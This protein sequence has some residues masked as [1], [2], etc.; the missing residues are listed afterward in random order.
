MVT[1][2]LG[3]FMRKFKSV[4]GVLIIPALGRGGQEFEAPVG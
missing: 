2:R 1:A 4:T 3:G